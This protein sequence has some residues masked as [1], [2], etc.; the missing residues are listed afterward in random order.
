MN[1]ID[2][3]IAEWKAFCAGARLPFMSADELLH[4]KLTVCYRPAILRF[5]RRWD[6]AMLVLN[7]A[8]QSR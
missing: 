2:A 1:E 3:L 8:R 5:I 6:A 4:D 7:S